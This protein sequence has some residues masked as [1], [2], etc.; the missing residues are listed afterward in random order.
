MKPNKLNIS[1]LIESDRKYGDEFVSKQKLQ[2]IVNKLTANLKIDAGGRVL[3][4]EDG[5]VLKDLSKTIAEAG[6]FDGE[7]LRFF[8]KSDK[9][10]RDKGF[11]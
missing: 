10:G 7:V 4:R 3:R 11:A 6:I 2:V 1:V 9:P 5:T 8:V